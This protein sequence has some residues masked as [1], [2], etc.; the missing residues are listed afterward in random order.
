MVKAYARGGFPS[1][2]ILNIF[3]ITMKMIKSQIV[4]LLVVGLLL[5]LPGVS[6]QISQRGAYT[7][8]YARY[9]ADAGAYGRE[10]LIEGPSY[11][12]HLLASEASQKK[13]VALK[14]DGAFVQWTLNEASDAFNIRF[15]LP[16]SDDGTGTTGTVGVYVNETLVGKLE[17][18]SFHAWQYFDK[19]EGS[20]R[21]PTNDSSVGNPRMR[22]DE[23]RFILPAQANEGDVIK[24]EKLDGP[25]C[26]IDFIETEVIPDEIQ[27]PRGFISVTDRK[28]GAIADD[29]KDDVKAFEKAIDY[30][31]KHDVGIYIPK[32]KYLL[33]KALKITTDNMALQGAGI[34]YTH[35]HW[36]G[37]SEQK[38][39]GGIFGTGNNAHV[40]HFYMTS[41]LNNRGGGYRA[42]SKHWGQN[43]VIENIWLSHFSVGF[44]TA[45]G[46]SKTTKDIA[47]HLVIRNC[48][49]RNTY[50]DGCNFARGAS[51]CVL[52]FCDFRNNGDDAMAT[53]SHAPE[54][55]GPCTNNEFRFNTVE[56]VT[57]AAGIGIFGGQQHKVHHCIIRDNFSGAGIRVNSTFPAFP[58]VDSSLIE[59]YEMTVERCGTRK[60][61][62][63]QSIGAINLLTWHYDVKGIK[64]SDIDVI[65]AQQDGVLIFRSDDKA[66]MTKVY[67]ENIHIRG[68]GI[69]QEG[70]GYGIRVSD[71]C[72]GWVKI[73]NITFEGIKSDDI[74]EN[75]P[76]FQLRR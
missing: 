2:D 46:Y 33:S 37:Y 13:Y 6:Q 16:D 68:T 8:P 29:D 72:T 50:A 26:G 58:Y 56:F 44:W 10:A 61:L 12:Q 76:H 59:I 31:S 5:P 30:A 43:S 39:S 70:A 17:L 55:V 74:I 25:E 64:L 36:T 34:W 73:K 20:D 28:F 71:N 51:N 22:F 75:A 49:I 53:V 45:A 41:N 11:N 57:R 35:L 62:W 1:R 38:S 65:D 69:D 23:E 63:N 21:H 54:I 19:S 52:E 47:D 4:R 9:E 67:L 42:F 48:R 40:S 66:T 18:T 27:K 3:T 60:A 24:L 15:T 7:M 32:G 14:K